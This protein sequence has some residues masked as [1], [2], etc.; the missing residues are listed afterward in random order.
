[1]HPWQIAVVSATFLYFVIACGIYVWL[2]TKLKRMEA[3]LPSF[4]E[5]RTAQI[6]F[7]VVSFGWLLGLGVYLYV[8]FIEV[9]GK[10]ARVDAKHISDQYMQLGAHFVKVGGQWTQ[11]PKPPQT[12]APPEVATP[13][14]VAAKPDV[15]GEEIVGLD[16]SFL[17]KTGER[18]TFKAA[19]ESLVT[20]MLTEPAPL[21]YMLKNLFIWAKS[22]MPVAP[23]EEKING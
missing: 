20:H 19:D 2:G 3:Y 6:S 15:E 5:A 14:E 12:Q 7:L 23:P 17:V 18:Y 9:M 1:M 10:L 21:G 11:Q 16:V 8:K 22:P 13:P 4:F